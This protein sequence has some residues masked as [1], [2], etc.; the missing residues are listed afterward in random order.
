MT[1]KQK[2]EII[3][4]QDD[5]FVILSKLETIFEEEKKYEASVSLDQFYFYMKSSFRLHEAIDLISSGKSALGAAIRA[6]IIN[7]GEA[8]K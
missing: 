6:S 3:R 4:I 8:K 2:A 1:A 7:E 5:L